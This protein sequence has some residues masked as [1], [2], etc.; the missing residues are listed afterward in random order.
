[1]AGSPG[2]F[3]VPTG[4][5]IANSAGVLE[6]QNTIVALNTVHSL[7]PNGAPDCSGTITSLGNNIIGDL[8]GCDI[9]LAAGNL[10]TDPGLG[11]FHGRRYS[12][13]RVFS[14]PGK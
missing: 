7:N 12:W 10:V 6:L 14:S 9:I 11:D 1:V 2:S 8:K 3:A 4:G 5:G 13:R